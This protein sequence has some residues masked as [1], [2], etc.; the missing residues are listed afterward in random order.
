M[1]TTPAVCKVELMRS[2]SIQ[3]EADE[4]VNPSSAGVFSDATT[5]E[6]YYH[7]PMTVKK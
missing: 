2:D 5:F 7:N 4:I 6:H 1:K 3:L